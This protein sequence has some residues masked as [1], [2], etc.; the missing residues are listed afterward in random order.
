MIHIPA[1]MVAM[2][3][4]MGHDVYVDGINPLYFQLV[5]QIAGSVSPVRVGARAH[6]GVHHYDLTLRPHEK[7]QIIE[8]ELSVF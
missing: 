7:V 4:G 3:M 8:L 2:K 6:A 5:D 1:H